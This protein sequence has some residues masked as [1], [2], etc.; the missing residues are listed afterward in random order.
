M[1]GIRATLSVAWMS[2][3]K[4]GVAPDFAAHSASKTR[5]NALSLRSF[6]RA[7]KVRDTEMT[8]LL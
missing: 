1:R 6:I 2:E 8:H 3:V 5:V 7:T 4:S